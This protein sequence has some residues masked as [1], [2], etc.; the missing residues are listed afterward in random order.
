[1]FVNMYT[2]LQWNIANLQEYSC[3][4][5]DKKMNENIQRQYGSIAPVLR[6]VLKILEM[7]IRNRK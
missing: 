3:H 7:H 5:W 1:M 6:M 4:S 2:L